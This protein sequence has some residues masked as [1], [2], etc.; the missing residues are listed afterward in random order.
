M[1]VNR[2]DFYMLKLLVLTIFS[3]IAPL[4]FNFGHERLFLLFYLSLF[5]V[6][7]FIKFE[8]YLLPIA[9]LILSTINV[10]NLKSIELPRAFDRNSMDIE[11]KI[12]SV[13]IS[14]SYRGGTDF[15]KA[16]TKLKYNKVSLKGVVTSP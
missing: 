10:I 3:L 11:Y 7:G 1:P 16:K 5:I 12:S 9:G 14:E 13:N 8:F 4:I 2:K 6:G 15:S